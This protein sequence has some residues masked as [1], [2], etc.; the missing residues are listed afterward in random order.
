ML[1]PESQAKERAGSVSVLGKGHLPAFV[2]ESSLSYL[3][4]VVSEVLRWEV[5]APLAIPHSSTGEDN[6]NGYTILNGAV[7]IRN[8]WYVLHLL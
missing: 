3:S 7:V 5:V 8:S 2:D 4:V 6:N 1:H